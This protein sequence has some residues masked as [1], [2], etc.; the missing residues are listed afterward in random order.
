MHNIQKYLCHSIR[1]LIWVYLGVH[2]LQIPNVSS[3]PMSG[4]SSTPF[5]LNFLPFCSFILWAW[6]IETSKFMA[7]NKILVVLPPTRTFQLLA[8]ARFFIW[9]HQ[10]SNRVSLFPP[11]EDKLLSLF[12]QKKKKRSNIL[13]CS[14]L[15]SFIA[16]TN[17]SSRIRLRA[18]KCSWKKI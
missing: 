5:M 18:W 7:Q 12:Y 3:Y 2:F 17:C 4:H 11:I 1:D 14:N 10:R 13:S 8:N 16:Q 9:R 15:F 6:V